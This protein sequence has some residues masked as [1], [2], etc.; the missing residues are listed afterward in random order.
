MVIQP[1]QKW[2]QQP[3]QKWKQQPLQKW[4]QQPHRKQLRMLERQF[5]ITAFLIFLSIR[6]NE[7][8]IR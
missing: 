4:K 8:S 6:C 1:L 7:L 3:L 5:E 2:K